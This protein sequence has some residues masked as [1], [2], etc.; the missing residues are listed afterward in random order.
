MNISYAYDSTG[1]RTNLLVAQ[2]SPL[3][4]FL[5]QSY[6]YDNRNRVTNM[7]AN[8]KS[9]TFTYDA[10]SRLI[11]QV[12][13]NG[14]T[15][16]N[17]FDNAH[18][19]LSRIHKK[20]DTTTIASFLYGYDSSGNRTNMTTLEGVNAYSSNS[21][22]WL[23]AATYPGGSSQQFFYDSVGNRTNLVQIVMSSTNSTVYLYN[24]V[25]GLTQSI[26]G[27]TTNTFTYDAS[28]QLTN[29]SLT[30]LIRSFSYSFRSQMTALVDTNGV[31][32]SFDFDG[33][34]H[35]VKQGVSG[36]LATRFVYDG[37]DVVLDLNESNQVVYVYVN[38]L[39]IDDKVER[40]AYLDDF[41]SVRLVFHSDALGSVVAISDSTQSAVKTYRYEAFGRILSESGALAPNRYTFT[42][43]EMFSASSELLY[44][45][46]RV[47][48]SSIGR[49]TSEDP[50]G[51][52]DGPNV[53]L[54]ANA[55]P[56]NA[57]DPDGLAYA[58]C[59]LLKQWCTSK[60]QINVWFPYGWQIIK[61]CTQRKC[62]WR[63]YHASTDNCPSIP[64]PN[65]SCPLDHGVE[66]LKSYG[67]DP[68]KPYGAAPLCS[69][70]TASILASGS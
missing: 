42:S 57:I 23:T 30:G 25:N 46:W 50:L 16:T 45:R 47:Y 32:S 26:T 60:K 34:G 11:A 31:V 52:T 61:V 41:L 20:T 5:N 18:Q 62:K 44:Y 1:N 9:T 64:C 22:N 21:N 6:A 40:L 14:T 36:C 39:S 69:E 33:D 70:K 54:Y 49:F 17:G 37:P 55:D 63:C 53:A 66:I 67:P 15:V 48:S 4:E 2:A 56:V 3:V 28:G 38:G 13:P 8:G 29:Q 7:T 24:G 27:G 65:N 19:L 10:A 68:S 58:T 59:K 43:R 51:F 12:L 35:R